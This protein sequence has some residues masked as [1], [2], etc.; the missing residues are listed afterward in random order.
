MV[1]IIK[2]PDIKYSKAIIKPPNITQ[3][4]LPNVFISDLLSILIKANIIVKYVFNIKYDL[5]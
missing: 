5:F 1:S 2:N 4:I 3:I